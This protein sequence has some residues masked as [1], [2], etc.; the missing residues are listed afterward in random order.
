MKPITDQTVCEKCWIYFVF[1]PQFCAW[2]RHNV[3][4]VLTWVFFLWGHRLRTWCVFFFD[5]TSLADVSCHVVVALPVPLGQCDGCS[6]LSGHF[7]RHH[8]TASGYEARTDHHPHDRWGPLRFFS[9]RLSC[10]P[11]MVATVFLIHTGGERVLVSA[12][13]WHR[14]RLVLAPHVF[15]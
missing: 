12:S 6:A 4:C 15:D 3:R 13:H 5:S 9:P 8:P 10:S 7:L 2:L 14:N 11:A 1:T